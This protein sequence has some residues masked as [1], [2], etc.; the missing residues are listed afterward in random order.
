MLKLKSFIQ[1]SLETHQRSNY[2]E[3]FMK[4]K[5]II[6]NDIYDEIWE[7]MTNHYREKLA[8]YLKTFGIRK[9]NREKLYESEK[10]AMYRESEKSIKQME[11][12]FKGFLIRKVIA[13]KLSNVLKVQNYIRMSKIRTKYSSLK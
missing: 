12:Y 7:R 10:T 11:K 3:K 5:K 6:E 9:I 1:S 4:V 13:K 2:Y 8:V